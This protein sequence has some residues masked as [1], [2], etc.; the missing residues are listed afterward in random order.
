MMTHTVVSVSADTPV[1]DIARTLIA[2]GISAVPVLDEAG[3]IVG[4]VSEGDL[5]RRDDSGT[6]RRPSWWLRMFEL[7]ENKAREYAKTHG[8]HAG[9]VMTH[10]VATVSEDTPINEIAKL[11]ESRRIKRVP[12]VRNG[13][14]V[15]IVSRANLLFGLAALRT[16]PAANVADDAIQA[17]LMAALKKAGVRTLSVNILVSDGAVDIWGD[18]ESEDE[19]RAAGIA[20]E[21]VPGVIEV[22]NRAGVMSETMKSM[23]WE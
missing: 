6:E 1:S 23:Y 8:L 12:V 20:A 16:L 21:G 10:E 13:K 11:L 4:I 5:M 19:R 17:E 9:D 14:P 18:V 2:R 7:P 15:G 22:R 3:K